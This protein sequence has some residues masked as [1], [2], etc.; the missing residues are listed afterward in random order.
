MRIHKK[1]QAR[2]PRKPPKKSAKS[3]TSAKNSVSYRTV[4]GPQLTPKTTTSR[5]CQGPTP[6]L[7]FPSFHVGK[8]RC[9]QVPIDNEPFRQTQSIVAPTPPNDALSFQAAGGTQT[10]PNFLQAYDV[11]GLRPQTQFEVPIPAAPQATGPQSF[12]NRGLRSALSKH[13]RSSSPS[14]P[15]VSS[16]YPIQQIPAIKTERPL[17]NFN[18]WS[19]EL[20]SLGLHDYPTLEQILSEKSHSFGAAPWSYVSVDQENG[21]PSIPSQNTSFSEYNTLSDSFEATPTDDTQIP[22]HVGYHNRSSGQD[23]ASGF[24]RDF[25]YLSHQTHS[26]C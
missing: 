17:Q 16:I 18:P 4:S 9:E 13:G 26:P 5:P 12:S 22:Q 8:Q 2:Q 1:S 25:Q 23:I 6:L 20:S 3:F 24:V 21:L 7:P 15:Q 14:M 11:Q 10:Q 19:S